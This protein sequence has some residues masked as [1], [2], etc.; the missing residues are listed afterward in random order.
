MLQ[1]SHFNKAQK[2]FH[3]NHKCTH[4]SWFNV[5]L[6]EIWLLVAQVFI[7]MKK[8][9]SLQ[10]HNFVLLEN[11]FHWIFSTEEDYEKILN[12]FCELFQSHFQIRFGVYENILSHDYLCV[13]IRSLAQYKS[14]YKYVSMNPL[15]AKLCNHPLSYPYSTLPE[16]LGDRERVIPA[17]D[18]LGLIYRPQRI[19]E[20][21]ILPSGVLDGPK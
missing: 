3:Y 19:E 8:E 5:P 7:K 16:L 4:I 14:T 2:Y 18:F 13:E 17:V 21:L 15:Q 11:H 12:Q 1:R 9:H 6:S 10:I 20:W